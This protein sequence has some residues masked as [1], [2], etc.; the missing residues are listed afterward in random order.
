VR[1]FGRLLGG[2][3]AVLVLTASAG[4]ARA[5]E[6]PGPVQW[7]VVPPPQASSGKSDPSPV[8]WPSL[9]P[10]TNSDSSSD[11]K[12]NDWPAPQQK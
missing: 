11:P 9:E 5:A 7:P 10:P 3:L 12:P 8:K 4:V 1:L 2:V 6:D